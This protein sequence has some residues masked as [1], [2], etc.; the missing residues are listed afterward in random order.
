M[1]RMLI[2]P[3]A[4]PGSRL[5]SSLPKILVPVNGR[6]MIDRVLE[7]YA[8]AVQRVAV[9]VHPSAVTA[10]RGALGPAADM[11]VQHEPTGMLDAILLAR[12]AVEVHRPRRVLIT[13][14]DQVAIHPRT[15]A[16][17]CAATTAPADP[18]LILPTCRT[19][20]PY[21]HFERDA[22]GRILRIL[23]RREADLMPAVGESDAGVFDL[24]LNAYVDLLPQYAREADRSNS[25]GERNFLPFIAWLSSRASVKTF[26]CIDAEEAIGVNTPDDLAR[27]ERYLRNRSDH[28]A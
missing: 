16:L 18:L 8:N 28:D 26:P 20:E 6:P 12:P 25:T 19:A 23:H 15:I 11:F 1:E 17:L 22:A 24:S 10:V 21:T 13:W 4:G 14:C 3:A 2:V 7:L 5:R 9:I 27:V